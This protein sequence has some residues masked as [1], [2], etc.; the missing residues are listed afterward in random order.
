MRVLSL[1]TT[2]RASSVALVVDGQVV[3]ERSGDPHR[4]HAE[5][6]PA[7]LLAVLAAHGLT[8]SDVDVFAVASGPGSFTGLRIGIATMQGAAFVHQRPVVGIS[9]LSAL[10]QLGSVGAQPGDLVAALMDARRHDVFSALYEVGHAGV[11]EPDRLVAVEP[12]SVGD[13]LAALER[14]HAHMARRTTTFLGDGAVLYA[15]SI[16]QHVAT[17]HRI[18]AEIPPLAG[19]LGR[20]AFLLPADSPASSGASLQALYVR[21]PDVEIERDRKALIAKDT[22]D[23]EDAKGR[24]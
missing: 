11:F 23:A 21:R 20:M 3:E 4:A 9:A 15:E 2:T 24:W 19:A 16:A 5:R 7:D 10:A 22:M 12:P 17:P 14:W 13:P 18:V 6:L 1:D 8:L